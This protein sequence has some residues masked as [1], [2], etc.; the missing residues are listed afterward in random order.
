MSPSR[1]LLSLGLPKD[2][3]A[4]LTRLG[5]ETLQD[6]GSI[7]AEELSEEVKISIGDARAVVSRLQGPQAPATTLLMTQS[8]ALM[9]QKSQKI[10]TKCAA[11]D[12]ILG[13]GLS[14]GQILEISGPPGSPKEKIALNIVSSFAESGEETVFVDCQNAANPAELRNSL[15]KFAKNADLGRFIYPTRIQTLPELLLFLHHLPAILES[16][17]KVSLLVVNSISFPFQSTTS[18][19]ISQKNSI[20]DRVKQALSK[21]AAS[22][23]LT[24]V[25]TSQLATK[26][27]N[28]DGSPGTF[29]TGARGVMLPSLGPGYLPS[30]KSYRVILSPDGLTSG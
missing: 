21:G 26:M 14:R 28:A 6:L 9:V 8:A 1:S 10:L 17:P 25:T 2:V 24:I 27:I 4:A 11:L 23:K 18:F 30:S 29:D 15:E 13:G 20:I 5:Y 3:L 7:T 12:K 16:H 19:P 22:Q